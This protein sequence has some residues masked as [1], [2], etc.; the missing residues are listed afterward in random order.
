MTEELLSRVFHIAL[1]A[2]ILREWQVA[3]A[4]RSPQFN[5]REMLTLEVINDFAPITEKELCKIFGLSP[6]SVNEMV[7]KLADLGLVDKETEAA[8][9]RAKPLRLTPDGVSA[10]EGIKA[11]SARRF[12]YLFASLTEDEQQR[13]LPVFEKIGRTVDTK[14]REMVFGEFVR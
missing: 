8:D 7:K 9:K 4:A 5:D 12:G 2:R 1:R 14:V 13:L 3:H 10:L 6:S 11:G